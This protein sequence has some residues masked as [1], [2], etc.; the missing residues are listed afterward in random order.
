MRQ[1]CGRLY[2]EGGI[3]QADDGSFVPVDDP[4]ERVTIRSKRKQAASMGVSEQISESSLSLIH[5]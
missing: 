4:M 1:L 2:E 5:I 3:K